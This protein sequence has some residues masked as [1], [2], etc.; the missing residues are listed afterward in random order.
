MPLE[1][2]PT[3]IRTASIELGNDFAELYRLAQLTRD[4]LKPLALSE[5][6]LF[7]IDL[8]LEELATNIVKYGFDDKE[9]HLIRFEFRLQPRNVEIKLIDDGVAFDPF[10]GPDKQLPSTLEEA[11]V[12]GLG[13][14]L[15]KLYTSAFGYERRE[16]RNI[17][18]LSFQV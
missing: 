5:E 10:A 16:G 6:A 14:H 13:V 4:I 1:P 15:V 8:V 9:R 7:R 18:T 3:Q 12:G 2:E 17:T 11:Q